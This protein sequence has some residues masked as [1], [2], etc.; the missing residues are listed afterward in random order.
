MVSDRRGKVLESALVTFGRYG[1]RKASMD[2]VAQD[3]DISRP[4]LYFLFT[5][6]E[7]LFRAAVS[8]ALENDLAEVANCLRD[9]SLPLRRRLL[10]AFDHW[11]GR[12]TGPV[13]R[14]IASVVEHNP[15]LLGPITDL[16]PARFAEL[17]TGAVSAELPV[18]ATTAAEVVQTLVSTSVG[19][20]HQV[21]TRAEYLNR[22]TVAIGLLTR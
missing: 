21:D 19:L 12:Y 7:D 1:Y 5:S 6:K 15:D 13:M 2:Q 8:R 4:G 17:V 18:S 10:D 11:A 20:K 3:A 9:T 16:A 22:M 14:D